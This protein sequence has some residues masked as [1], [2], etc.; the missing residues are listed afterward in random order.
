MVREGDEIHIYN[1]SNQTGDDFIVFDIDQAV[2]L[3]DLI[4]EE[5]LKDRSISQCRECG[6]PDFAS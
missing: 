5:I 1:L 6:A 3:V 2:G 4:I